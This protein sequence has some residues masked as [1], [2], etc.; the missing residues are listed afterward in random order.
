MNM[1]HRIMTAIKLAAALV[2]LTVLALPAL[3]VDK[4]TL[5]DGRTLSGTITREVEGIIWIKYETAG[6]SREEMLRPDEVSKVE[7]DAA[8][9]EKGPAMAASP[10]KATKPAAVNN[11]MPK[12]AVITLG[13]R[14]TNQGDEI[15]IYITEHELK[16]MIPLLEQELGTDRTGVVVLRVTSG[17]GLLLEI[18][19]ISDVLQNE[20]KKRWRTV[21]WIDSAISAAAMSSLCL[22][23]IYFT[24]QGNFGAC[25]GWSGALV[26]VKGRGLE[27]VLLMMEKISARGNH[28]PKIMRSMQIQEPLSA[29]IDANGDVHFYQDPTSGDILVNRPHEI[30]TFNAQT[31]TKVKFSRGTA[32][33]TAELAKLM[34]YEELDWA[35]VPETGSPWKISKAEKWNITY[36][37]QVHQDEER[38]SEYARNYNMEIQAAEGAPKAQRGQFVNRA[39]ST[40]EKI[41]AAYRLNPNFGLLKLNILDEKEFKEWYEKQEKFLRDLM[42]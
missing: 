22:E 10:D 23:E 13:S 33:T 39:R 24:P 7:R 26:A 32:S 42:R 17:G 41:K 11:G 2:C 12:A 29:T 8:S 18:Q 27:E 38:F 16:E 1:T 36:R 3:A 31:A 5:K 14:D 9:P 35:G 20:Y 34:G 6:I 21:G 28:D 15:G 40:L 25:T 19:R 4:V 30:L 37:K